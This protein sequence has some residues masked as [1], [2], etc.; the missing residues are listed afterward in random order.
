MMLCDDNKRHSPGVDSIDPPTYYLRVSGKGVSIV[1]QNEP[2]PS[3][4]TAG[5][6]FPDTRPPH[7]CLT[8]TL[9]RCD[10]LYVM[11]Q[12]LLNPPL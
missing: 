2:F 4:L 9:E 8:C 7:L 11:G 3:Y 12:P 1:L 5:F 6:N 10:E